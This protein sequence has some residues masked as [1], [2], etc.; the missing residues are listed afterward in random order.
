MVPGNAFSSPPRGGDETTD[1][2]DIVLPDGEVIQAESRPGPT[3]VG[4]QPI[5]AGHSVDARRP[6]ESPRASFTLT[7]RDSRL[8]DP[9]GLSHD[10]RLT[11]S[12]T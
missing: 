3:E 5:F 2:L 7:W 6:Q 9:R 8:V 11:P 10:W 12:S 1:T 4:P